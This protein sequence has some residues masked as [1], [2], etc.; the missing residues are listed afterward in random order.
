MLVC[1][2]KDSA[3]FGQLYEF[4]ESISKK[5]EENNS[6]FN[7]YWESIKNIILVYSDFEDKP[8]VQL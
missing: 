3:S 8:Q 6:K 7:D 1:L 5:T 2:F 4:F